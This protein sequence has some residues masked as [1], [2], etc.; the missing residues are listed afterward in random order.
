MQVQGSKPELINYAI[1]MQGLAASG[2]VQAGF[3]LLEKA[4]IC[5]LL[6]HHDDHCYAMLHALL[7]ACRKVGDSNGASQ[8][9]AAIDRLGMIALAPIATALVQGS[10]RLYEYGVVGE[11]VAD[12]QQH[13][14]EL[15]QQMAY[16]PQLQ[17][18]PWGFVQRSSCG[19][20]E[21]T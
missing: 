4:E 21:L 20:Q 6:S 15:R 13:W 5:G 9:Q 11:G 3:A 2:Q 8:V 12:A 1:S 17:A 14:L 10:M 19:Q 18:L 7:Q 16:K